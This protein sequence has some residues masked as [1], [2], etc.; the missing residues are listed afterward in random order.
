[1]NM[2]SFW[3]TLQ[4]ALGGNILNLL[5]ALA[6][7]AAGL[8]LAAIA[9]SA[10]L[11]LMG[12]AGL[13]RRMG[14]MVGTGF[15]LENIVAQ[16]AFFLVVLAALVATF[17]LLDISSLSGPLGDMLHSFLSAVPKIIKAGILGLVAFVLASLLKMAVGR[18]LEATGVENKLVSTGESDDAVAATAEKTNAAQQPES[19]SGSLS[20]IVFWLV[21]L[22]FIPA[23][24]DAL[25]LDGLLVPV[26]TM[27]NNVLGAL[28]NVLYA[29]MIGFVGWI[30]AKLLRNITTSVVSS[31]RTEKISQQAGLKGDF[32]L[33]RLAG[34]MVYALVLIPT[35]IAALEQLSIRA[36]SDPAVSMLQ[37][38]MDAIPNIIAAVV[39]I[40][41]AWFLARFVSGLVKNLLESSG[42]D[43]MPAKIGMDNIFSG[44]TAPSRLASG[45]LMFFIMLFAGVSAF[46]QLHLTQ[47]KD[48]LTNLTEFAGDI[49]LGSIIMV[50]GFWLSN[51]VYGALNKGE[52]TAMAANIARFA[53]MGLVMAMGLRAM[54]IA[55]EI[56]N[57]AFGL[58]LAAIAV[59][60]AL[61]F[62]LGGRDAAGKLL[63]RW[64]N[65]CE[66]KGKSISDSSDNSD[67]SK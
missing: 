24:L 48:L 49:L 8:I 59:A 67:S 15:N 45:L 37:Q 58:T 9:R 7:L 42:A 33:S 62:G 36:I 29:G 23:I 28:P 55:N 38:F 54:G 14:D 41:V 50:V 10:V 47:V 40:T 52:N 31:L 66:N 19:I 5:L 56:V 65:G 4:G 20:S 39:I 57:L 44:S 32:N 22:F 30:I 21:I 46:E 17:N 64:L 3:E 34:N 26:Q 25:A 63:D 35:L 43:D 13:N 16:G 2:S 18:A 12:R 60:V 53:I 27:L 11:R 6:V 51:M 1:M 61:A